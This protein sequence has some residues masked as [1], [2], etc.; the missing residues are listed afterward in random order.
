MLF[1]NLNT[2]YLLSL[3]FFQS[4]IS[5]AGMACTAHSNLQGQGHSHSG[6]SGGHFQNGGSSGGATVHHNSSFAAPLRTTASSNSRNEALQTSTNTSV[7]SSGG[8]VTFASSNSQTA[9]QNISTN[10]QSKYLAGNSNQ[11]GGGEM[12]ADDNL[13]QFFDLLSSEK[14]LKS[15]KI[16]FFFF[17]FS[18]LRHQAKLQNNID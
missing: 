2:F 1:F 9:G 13:T 3:I 15:G 4:Q 10:G 14:D 17:I 8:Y 11:N 6:F 5:P 16:I 12:K 7:T 18:V